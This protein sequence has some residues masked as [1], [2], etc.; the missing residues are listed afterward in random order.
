MEYP[1]DA[2]VFIGLRELMTIFPRIKQEE[3]VM[4][5]EERQVLMKMEKTLYEH[6]SVEKVEELLHIPGPGDFR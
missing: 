6:L 1:Q 3:A 4:N 5:S 2:G